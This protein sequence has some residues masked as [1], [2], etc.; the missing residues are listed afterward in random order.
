MIRAGVPLV[1]TVV[2]VGCAGG[3]PTRTDDTR[4]AAS[5]PV[6]TAA[7]STSA[8]TAERPSLLPE[9]FEGTGEKGACETY[10]S[11]YERCEPTLEP[12]IA[13]GDL[14][15]FAAEKARLEYLGKTEEGRD[16]PEA[17]RA[18]L[19]DLEKECP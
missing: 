12:K 17:C 11:L 2:A 13:K 3:A 14:R 16:L 9:R 6:T 10:L 15:S 18:L 5:S 1:V 4:A 8:P 19:A 7:A